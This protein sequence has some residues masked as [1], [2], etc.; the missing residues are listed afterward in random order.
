MSVQTQYE[1]IH[2]A[3]NEL[4]R[5]GET[6]IGAANMRIVIGRLGRIVPLKSITGFQHHFEVTSNF[7]CRCHVT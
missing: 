1:F 6:E 7:S 5:C 3:L 4:I 2:N